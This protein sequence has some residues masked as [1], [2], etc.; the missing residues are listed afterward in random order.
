M[1]CTRRVR[2][3]SSSGQVRLARL[4]FPLLPGFRAFLPL[5]V[6]ND[7]PFPSLV[8]GADDD[9][10]VR[11]MPSILRTSASSPAWLDS[12]D[13]P[14]CSLRSWRP[15]AGLSR[16][17]RLVCDLSSRTYMREAETPAVSRGVHIAGVKPTARN[18]P[19]HGAVRGSPSQKRR[20]IE[21]IA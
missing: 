12:A 11:P 3:C 15:L 2:L 14:R 8:G 17:R 9:R 19:G 7:A 1:V 21:L 20:W 5:Q 16:S 4:W 6:V 18:D 10:P 13:C